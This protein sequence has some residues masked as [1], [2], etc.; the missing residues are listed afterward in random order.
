MAMDDIAPTVLLCD[1]CLGTGRHA[2]FPAR[3]CSIC[4]G[5]GRRGAEC[6]TEHQT[7]PIDAQSEAVSRRCL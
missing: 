6:L 5:M 7:L 1:A 2:H 4:G 3:C